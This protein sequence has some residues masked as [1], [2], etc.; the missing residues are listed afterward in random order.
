MNRAAI[1]GRIALAAYFLLLGL[2]FAWVAV[3]PPP[4]H[5][6]R[7]LL[8]L[9][10][11]LPLALPV[12]GVLHDR[13]RAWFAAVFLSLVYALHGAAEIF[14]SPLASVLPYAELGLALLLFISTLLHLRRAS[15]TENPAP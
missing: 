7:P 1:S 9:I 2:V 13:P 6:P 3:F 11:V 5:W 15:Q 4:L 14:V 10:A 8:L 12:R